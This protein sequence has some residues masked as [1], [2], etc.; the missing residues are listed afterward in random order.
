MLILLVFL[1]I[2]TAYTN[3]TKKIPKPIKPD[4]ENVDVFVE[5]DWGTNENMVQAKVFDKSKTENPFLLIYKNNGV[6][7]ELLLIKGIIVRIFDHESGKLLKT[8]IGA[9]YKN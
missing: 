5:C 9:E 1:F 6:H 8:Y 2:I 7:D 3:T 4:Y